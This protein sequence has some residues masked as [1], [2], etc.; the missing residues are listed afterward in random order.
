MCFSVIFAFRVFLP[1]SIWQKTKSTVNKRTRFYCGSFLR[2]ET[3]DELLQLESTVPLHLA[4]QQKAL[5]IHT[6]IP[7]IECK[8]IHYAVSRACS[9]ECVGYLFNLYTAFPFDVLTENEEPILHS[10]IE[11]GNIEVIQLILDLA[12]NFESDAED[13]KETIDSFLNHTNSEG[14]IQY[15]FRIYSNDYRKVVNII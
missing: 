14:I 4:I 12:H 7:V 13:K 11:G 5:S 3:V 10:A 8:L 6:Q 15:C 2:K 9:I 1:F